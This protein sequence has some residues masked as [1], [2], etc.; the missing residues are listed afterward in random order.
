MKR[1]ILSLVVLAACKVF[2]TESRRHRWSSLRRR[3]CPAV[4]PLALRS[5]SS[6]YHINAE[7]PSEEYLIGTTVD[8]R[9]VPGVTF[10]KVISRPR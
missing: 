4:Y 3:L 5:R 7:I 10:G 2:Q 6:P 9:D 1:T 8:F